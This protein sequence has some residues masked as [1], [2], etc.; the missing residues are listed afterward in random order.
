MI[1]TALYT[2]SAM[3]PEQLQ[4]RLQQRA[5]KVPAKGKFRKAERK[6]WKQGL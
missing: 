5:Y 4:Q 1:N 2:K 6:S 3:T